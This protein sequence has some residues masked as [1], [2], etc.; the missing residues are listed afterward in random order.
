MVFV[1]KGTA[2]MAFTVTAKAPAAGRD[3][4]AA[5]VEPPSLVE[6]K[7][8][9]HRLLDEQFDAMWSSVCAEAGLPAGAS[10]V[11]AHQRGHLL[12][13]LV[14]HN[15]RCRMLA[16]GWRIRHVAARRLAELGR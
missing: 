15:S 8:S 4:R 2:G 3:G 7:T 11:D 1:T 14:R 5:A 9:L 12:D 13:A 16:T 6:I 10:E